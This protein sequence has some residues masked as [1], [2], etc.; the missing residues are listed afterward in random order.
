M[1]VARLQP[2]HACQGRG[3]LDWTISALRHDVELT[4]AVQ[5]AYAIW[6]PCM[7]EYWSLLGLMTKNTLLMCLQVQKLNKK[8]TELTNLNNF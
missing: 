4:S 8:A 5:Y 6:F 1:F 2:K 7:F 3:H